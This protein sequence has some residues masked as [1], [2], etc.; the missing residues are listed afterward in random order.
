MSFFILILAALPAFAATFGTVTTV[1]GSVSDILLDEPRRRL[2][3]VNTNA[4]RLE[5]FSLPPN[6]IRIIGTVALDS[7][8]LTMAMSPDRN[9]IIVTCHNASSLNIVD[10]NTLRVIARP[11]VPA[12]PEGVAIG[13]DGRALVSTIG[14]GPNNSQN[15]LLVFDPSTG[16]LDN[17]V[18]VPPTSQAPPGS[19]PAGRA[20]LANRSMLVPTPDGS[21]IVGV[22]IPNN[23]TRT[24]FVYEVASG[25][26]LRSRTIN[27]ISSVLTVSPDGQKFMSGLS[28]FDINTLEVL[29][30]QNLAN[31][32]YPIPNNTNFNTTTNQGGSVFAPDGQNLYAAFN[33][34]PT[35][36]PPARPN[37]SQLMVND[38][39]N[40]LIKIGFQ[41]AENLSGKMLITEDGSTIY[42]ISESGFMQIPIGSADRNPILDLSDTVAFLAN[43]QCGVTADQRR[44]TVQARNMGAGRLTVTAT[45]LQQTATGPAALGG[46]GGAGGGIIGGGV[47]IAL[48]G[49]LPGVPGQPGVNVGGT[50]N[51]ATNAVTQTAPITRTTNTQEGADIDLQFNMINTRTTGTVSP[52]HDFLIQSAQAINIPPRLRVYQNN[53]DAEASTDIRTIPIGI[54][55]NEALE[56]ITYDAVRSRVYIANSGR[57]RIEVFDARTKQ[58]MAP[59]KVGQLPRSMALT[60][61]GGTLYVANSGGENIS[62]VDLL[63]GRVS[64]RLKFPPLPFNATS[65]LVTPRVVVATTRGPLVVMSNGSLWRV[66]GNDLVPRAIS[67]VI[68]T[69]TLTNP[70]SAVATPNGEYAIV[71]AGNGNVYLY[72]AAADEFVQARQIFTNPIQG[73][74]GPIAAG[75]NGRYFLVNGTVLNPALTPVGS[76]GAIQM[77]GGRGGATTT[78][79]RPISSVAAV[80]ANQFLRFAQPIQ[81]QQQAAIGLN[82]QNNAQALA[83]LGGSAPVLELADASSGNAIRQFTTIEGPITSTNGTNRA[84]ISGRQL[85]VDP[86]GTTAYVITTSGLSVVPLN[87]ALPADRPV[88][89]PQGGILNAASGKTTVSPGSLIS[90]NGRNLGDTAKADAPYPTVLG[91]V[92]VTVNNQPVP[93]VST[94]A[95]RITAQLPPTLAAGRY[96]LVVRAVEKKTS[97]QIPSTVT[98]TKYAPAVL[99]DPDTKQ[100]S[101]FFADSNRPVTTREPATRDKR[102]IIYAVGLGPTKP[103]VPA[104]AITPS[105]PASVTDPV[106]V[107]F[108]DPRYKQAQVIVE[109]SQLAPGM[110]GI[111][112]IR[113]YVPGEHMNGNN[114]DVTIRVGGVDSPTKGPLDPTISLK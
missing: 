95:T 71:M 53:H 107:Y 56:D 42:A 66:V 93:L 27:N 91:G 36:N 62:V 25:I 30:Q 74:Y 106:S 92:C 21:L 99:V 43:D 8:P 65:A 100:A 26:V 84:N 16:K 114:L 70:V 13:N 90:I 37:I 85:T 80:S 113:I 59:I 77:A 69:A 47:I 94:S 41:M 40:L 98:L 2:Y 64:G 4:N 103:V 22:N 46:A 104:G 108:G 11:N 1:V 86:Q 48:P 55:A 96:P 29:A 5:I 111:Y 20:F 24:V 45:V 110:V 81:Q 17:V 33:V 6:P 101:I 60:P 28:L 9:T 18:I 109:S 112:A 38:P 32:P 68:G 35:Q 105:S 14:T 15:T 72:D 57:N 87:V 83:A 73:Y 75:P 61:D 44:T 19:P 79:A 12:R 63:E 7:L 76:A 82:P 31:A 102:L 54:S 89:T 3:A 52:F 88:V 50:V 39:D 78:V 97:T 10:L 67:P 34:A 51:N 58:F 49:I 23:T